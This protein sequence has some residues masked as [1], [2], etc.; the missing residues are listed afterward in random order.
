[1]DGAG[2]FSD[3]RVPGAG[4]DWR[5]ELSRIVPGAGRDRTVVDPDSGPSVALE[6]D[7]ARVQNRAPRAWRKSP[8][9][10]ALTLT[11]RPVLRGRRGW[12]HTGIDWG[13]LGS[14]ARSGRLDAEQLDWFEELRALSE[15]HRGSYAADR[16]QLHMERYTSPLL[17][18]VLARA[19]ALGI[20]VV[21]R[22][23]AAPV[24]LERDG[25]FEVRVAAGEHGEL[26]LHPQLIVGDHEIPLRWTRIIGQPGH[27][28]FYPEAS[29]SALDAAED[30]N[31]FPLHLVVLGTR[32]NQQQRSFLDRAES[33]TVPRDGVEEFFETYFPRLH[34]SMNV[35]ADEDSLVLPQVAD[36]EFV[37][38]VHHDDLTERVEWEWEYQ[39]GR[40]RV[41]LPFRPVDPLGDEAV[42]RESRWESSMVQAV[43]RRI[44]EL[45]FRRSSY[46]AEDALTFLREWLP[47]LRRIP[48]LRIEETGGAP[49]YREVSEPTEITVSTAPTEHHDWFGLGVTVKVGEHYLPFAEIF[50]ALDRGQDVMLLRD[51]S[52]FP[53]DRP[54]FVRLRAL[55]AEARTLQEDKNAPLALNRYQTSLWEQFEELATD[56]RQAEAWRAGVR[57]LAHL[58]EVPSP[59]VPDTLQ[60]SLRPYQYEG[61]R[62]LSF[63]WE[64]GLGGV[65]AD[66]M[67]LGK[68]VQTIAAMLRAT[69]LD[70]E[71]PPY[72]VIA[73]TSVVANWSA[74]LR[75]FAPSL[76]VTVLTTTKDSVVG[77]A[78]ASHVV[79]TSYALLRLD[80][81]A[82]QSVEWAGVVMDEA[83]F[84][85]NPRTKAYRAVKNLH[86]RTCLAITGTPMENSLSE[87]WSLLS[88]TAPGLF[89]SRKR[90]TEHYQRPIE[91]AMDSDAL[92]RLRARMR[93]FMLRRSKSDV[94]LQLPPKLEHV[95]PVGLNAEHRSAYD[96]RLQRERA[97][98][99]G[100]LRDFD[101]NRFTIFQSLTTLRM[102]AL[103]PS[104]VDPDATAASSKLD[105]LFEQLPQLI[106]EGHRPLVFSQFTS[107]LKIM[108]RRLDEA[109]IAYSYLDG[110]TRDRA[111]AL[112]RFRSGRAPVFLVSLKAGGFGINLT[113]ADY[114]YLLDPWWNPAA[115]NQAVD[116]THRIGQTKKVM[117][118]R[119]VAQDTIEEKVMEL[120]TRK[121]DLFSAVLDD[122]HVFSTS[123]DAE[124]IRS[125]V[126]L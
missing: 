78:R 8:E 93:P 7:L 74:E 2:Q 98:I 69:S 23:S 83:Q 34:Q 126:G 56:T 73:P 36:P 14:H 45:D 63:L 117:V 88:L 125:L 48:D 35:T 30:L 109:G 71:L 114:C 84:V 104:L 5:S 53:L 111:G 77:A 26:G 58:D 85:K 33:L 31:Q 17:W 50:Q 91:R 102:L 96:R 51:G 86:A 105:V 121:A 60:A 3:T 82:Y 99:L 46:A 57:A 13:N 44:P 92:A 112:D 40:E 116:R 52:Y 80:A 49:A 12:V 97:K 25:R 106:Q 43:H 55:I 4:P 64:H 47:Q 41:R 124:D 62:W 76:D 21:S 113:E 120:K 89:P 70:P 28:L 39:K 94:D 24:V 59:P 68:T 1:M 103:D 10:I 101:K 54:E 6:L 79:L 27:G 108:A 37:L 66:D 110:S 9:E 18:P 90:F 123:L 15:S 20:P 118:Y 38:T 32:L 87:L 95:L 81:E 107:F 119:M 61:F 115:E 16:H 29:P 100:L 22:G 67:G 42:A 72:L 65:I 11:A 122:D 19:G 75:R